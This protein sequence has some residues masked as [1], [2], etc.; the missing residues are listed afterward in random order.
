MPTAEEMKADLK[1]RR[2]LQGDS[3]AHPVDYFPAFSQPYISQLLIHERRLLVVAQGYGSLM[4]APTNRTSPI[5]LDYM[6]THVRL[7]DT[8]T[9]VGRRTQAQDPTLQLIDWTNLNGYFQA[10]RSINGT[11]HMVCFSGIDTYT[12]LVAPF[13]IYSNGVYESGIGKDQYAANATGLAEAVIKKFVDDIL[14]ELRVGGKLP[15]LVRMNI[16]QNQVSPTGIERA[17]YPAGLF[18][19]V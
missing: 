18:G 11:A 14:M 12:D 9:I 17:T 6:A 10:V 7:Y 16:W 15:N 2:S 5:L 4:T 8:T 19:G 1:T 13:D 3:A